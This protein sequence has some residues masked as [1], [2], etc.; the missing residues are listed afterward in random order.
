MT[1][2]TDKREDPPD[3]TAGQPLK[4]VDEPLTCVWSGF[5]GHERSCRSR[6][7]AGV[8]VRAWQREMQL[9]GAADGFFHFAWRSGVWL[10]YGLGEGGVRGV[11]CP[12]H[13]AE[14]ESRGLPQQVAH[15]D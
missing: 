10:G 5:P 7:P 3:K 14:R 6:I 12:A 9:T 1:D 15:A 2:D 8:V 13:R 4:L 11:Y